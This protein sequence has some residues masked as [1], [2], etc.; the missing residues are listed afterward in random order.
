MKKTYWKFLKRSVWRTKA[1]FLS[2]LGIVAIGV[3]FLGGLM[4]STPDMQLTVDRYYDENQVHDIDIK[5]PMGITEE[6]I[7]ALSQME[8]VEKVTPGYVTDLLMENPEGSYVTRLYGMPQGEG[9]TNNF[10]LLEGRM[11]EGPDECLISIPNGYSLSIPVGTT[12]QISPDTEN[13]GDTYSFTQV[14]AVGVVET[15]LFFASASE[16]STV[17]SG[18]VQLVMLMT[19]EAYSMEV[20]T[21]AFLRLEGTEVLDTF[22]AA[23]TDKVET[24]TTELEKLGLERSQI[25][26]DE[27]TGDAGK[28]LADATKKYEDGKKEA[29]EKLADAKKELEDGKKELEENRQKLLDGEKELSDGKKALEENRKKLADGRAELEDGKKELAAGQEKY[30]EGKAELEAGKAEIAKNQEKLDSSKKDLDAGQTQLNTEIAGKK[31]E[32]LDSVPALAQQQYNSLSAQI[33]AAEQEGIAQLDQKEAEIASGEEQVKSGEAA[34]VQKEQELQAGYEQ[35]AS[36]KA[37]YENN[38]AYLASSRSQLEGERDRFQAEIAEKRSDLEAIKDTLTPEEYA[39]AVGEIDA[40]QEAGTAQLNGKFA[41]L[42][43]GEAELE[44]AAG[45]IAETEAALDSGSQALEAGKKEIAAAKAQLQEGRTALEAGRKQLK[46]GV[47]NK[48]RELENSRPQIEATIRSEGLKQIEAAR[49]EAQEKIDEGYRQLTQGQEQ[50]AAAKKKVQAGEAELAASK[51]QLDSAAAKIAESE[52]T[53]A[54]GETALAEGE[55]TLKDSESTIAKGKKELTEGEKKL[56]DGEAEYTEEKAKAEKELADAKEKLDEAKAEIGDIKLPEWLIYD[57]DDILSFSGYRDDSGKVEAIAT[58]FPIFFF[59]VAALVALTTM[60]R[61]VEEERTQIGVFKALGYSNST[62]TAYYL[63]YSMLASL[64]GSLIGIFLGYYTLPVIVA[65]A[66]GMMYTV[67]PLI[68]KFWWSYA[69]VIIPTAIACTTVSALGACLAQLREKPSTLMLQRAPQAGK[70][71]LLERLSPLWKR[72]SFTQK[73]T[74]RNIF[75]YKK[76]LLMT[77]IGIAGC[78]ALLVTGFGLQD[79]IQDI[80]DKQFGEI[81][82]YDASITLKDNVQ[83][84][85]DP[86]IQALLTDSS[87]VSSYAALHTEKAYLGQK[88]CT[89]MVPESDQAL[90][91]EVLLRNMKTKEQLAFDGNAAV[92]TQKLSEVLGVKVGDTVTIK[93]GSGIKGDITITGIAENYVQDNLFMGLELYRETF[94]EEPQYNEVLASLTGSGEIFRTDFSE[95]ILKCENALLLIYNQTIRDTFSD[96]VKSINSIVMVLIFSA[97]AL[98][99]IVL[100]NL[101]NINIC[102]RKKELATIKVLG[103]HQS[104]LAGYIYR[105]TTILCVIGILAGFILGI[106]LHAFVVQTAEMD[107]VMFGRTIYPLSYLFSALITLFFTALVDLLMLKKL[108]GID[109][110]ESMKANE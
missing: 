7:A 107:S 39:A 76:R 57:R 20:Y 102:E 110:V 58:I 33:D 22:S 100:Y 15:P 41:E 109:M 104:E 73:I 95:R 55:K 65:G 85:T 27:V 106:F 94:G 98:A 29:D 21:D 108:R 14:T 70:R 46:N 63:G 84:D 61:L 51:P 78:S 71:I 45:Q 79:S 6:D 99:M 40:A 43:A 34:L 87:L 26:Y 9:V 2:I 72:F 38:K 31:S 48:R 50:L 37:D 49:A 64:I 88:S 62:I 28:E 66:Y 3:G 12:F 74:A 81:Y 52:A 56:L 30:N 44:A 10:T 97:G 36:A 103:F 24:F 90:Q 13:A 82:R 19:P 68:T 17:G 18:S 69:L 105:E 67:P 47:A 83:L 59:L 77:I 75:R 53:I 93:S 8:G 96:T 5:G 60:T 89:I 54:A 35:L 32:F 25:R 91:K 11:P 4:A 101:T 42:E 16:P 1:R 86:E 80:A 23:Y 92:V